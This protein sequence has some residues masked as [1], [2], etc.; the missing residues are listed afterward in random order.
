[1]TQ[2]DRDQPSR[3]PDQPQGQDVT[4][5]KGRRD[6]VGRTGIYPSGGPYPEGEQPPI[7]TPGAINAPRERQPSDVQQSD[8]VKGAERLPRKG[9]EIGSDAPVR[10]E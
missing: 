8:A 3:P 5:G 10:G 7:L 9:D 1:M 2:N 4:A 6:E